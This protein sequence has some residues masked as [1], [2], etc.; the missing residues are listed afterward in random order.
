ML[1]GPSLAFETDAC[2]G[3]VRRLSSLAR[4]GVLTAAH[5]LKE[6]EGSPLPLKP[7]A[8]YQTSETT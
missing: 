7:Y 4:P 2:R 6:H 3:P 8:G 5:C 1:S